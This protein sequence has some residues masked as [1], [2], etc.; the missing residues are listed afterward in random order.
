VP[1]GD[2]TGQVIEPYLT[3]QWFVKMDGARRARPRTGGER[4]R[5][6]RAAELDQHLPPL[7]G[8]HPGL[9]HLAPALV[10]PPH[11]GL[12]RRRR[13]SSSR[14]TKRPRRRAEAAGYRGALRRDE[15]VLETWF[16]SAL[17]SHSAPW[18]GPMP[19]RWQ[20]GFD[21]LPADLGAGHRLRHHLLLGGPDDHDDRPLHR[22]VP[23]KHV[24]ITGLVRDKDGQKMSKSKGNILDPLD[25]I[26]GITIDA[27]VAKRTTG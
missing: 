5:Q 25:L 22:Q 11:P 9:V 16:S 14:A 2:R 3:D 1:R 18:A 12:V 4:Q 24:Y 6:V 21:V 10:G 19:T 23:F 13:Q 15:D 26:D 7:A 17:W 27:L 20:Y 8:Q